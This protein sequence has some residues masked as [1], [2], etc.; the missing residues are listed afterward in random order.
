[1]DLVWII[2]SKNDEYGF[3]V[4]DDEPVTGSPK[5]ACAAFNTALGKPSA[6]TLDQ[7]PLEEGTSLCVGDLTLNCL[8]VHKDIHQAGLRAR[9]VE[10]EQERLSIEKQLADKHTETAQI[11]ENLDDPR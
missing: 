2:F 10:L 1:M 8:R 6:V 3:S 5:D 11:L 7:V 4:F 9:L